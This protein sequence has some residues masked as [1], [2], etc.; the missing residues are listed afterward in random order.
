MCV[1]FFFFGVAFWLWLFLGWQ[2]YV[3]YM[4]SK[5]GEHPDDILKQN[6][7]ILAEVHRGRSV[8]LLLQTLQV[9]LPT[10]DMS[11]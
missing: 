9:F 7:Q 1:F 10:T 8:F 11:I 3:V 6:H 2:V 5:N 4:G